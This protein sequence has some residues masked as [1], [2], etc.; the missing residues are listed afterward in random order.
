MLIIII[1]DEMLCTWICWISDMCQALSR[2]TVLFR[3]TF[4]VNNKG[5]YIFGALRRYFFP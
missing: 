3:D 4:L 2:D 1:D 5:L